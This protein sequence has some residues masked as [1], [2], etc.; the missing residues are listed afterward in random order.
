M[1]II[2]MV[3][4]DMDSPAG[5]IT[6]PPIPLNFS[7]SEEGVITM[8]TD[9]KKPMA[10][11]TDFENYENDARYELDAEVRNLMYQRGLTDYTEAMK[12]VF[13]LNPDLKK[14]YASS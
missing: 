9:V 1:E 11:Y 8:S 10:F 3:I 7:I 2:K 4:E 5:I 6:G 14:R 13:T 12:L